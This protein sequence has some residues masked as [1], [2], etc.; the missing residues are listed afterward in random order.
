M[1]EIKIVVDNI[2]A[3]INAKDEA[4]RTA[5]EAIG[6]QA[7]GRAKAGCPVDTGLLRNSITHALDGGGAS[8]ESYS[9]N[10]GSQHGSYSGQ[11]ESEP[12]G[13][14]SVYIGS[15]VEYAPY[16]EDGARGR[17]P[18]HMLRNAL[19]NYQSEY[20]EIIQKMLQKQSPDF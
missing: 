5:L 1:A 17:S 13:R 4:I 12:E 15:N 2:D 6:I 16:V 10:S 14:A 8:T 20:V 18:K 11:T 19:A 3:V 7:E 9:D